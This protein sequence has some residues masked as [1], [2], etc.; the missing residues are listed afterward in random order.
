M[1]GDGGRSG[2]GLRIHISFG[3]RW[4]LG[5]GVFTPFDFCCASMELVFVSVYLLCPCPG[6]DSLSLLLQRK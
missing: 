2:A 6:R 4:R 1:S 3:C 5:C